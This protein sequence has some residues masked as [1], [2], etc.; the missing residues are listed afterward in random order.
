MILYKPRPQTL[1]IS[2][3]FL[4]AFYSYL[5]AAYM[6]AIASYLGTIVS[7]VFLG[8]LISRLIPTPQELADFKRG[9]VRLTARSNRVIILAALILFLVNASHIAYLDYQANSSVVYTLRAGNS[10]LAL[11]SDSWYKIVE[12]LRNEIPE[13][14][15]VISWW[16]YGYGISVDGEGHRSLMVLH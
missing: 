10:N 5:N 11:K 14:G 3:G 13:D 8:L 1:L 15:L 4:L 6:I 9:R 12:T 16:D 7:G 2:L